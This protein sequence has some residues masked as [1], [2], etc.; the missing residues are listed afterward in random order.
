MWF[1]FPEGVTEISVEQQNFHP[2]V[3]RERSVGER[4]VQFGFFR[5]PDHFAPT[6][7][8]LGM[9]FLSETPEGDLSELPPMQSGPPP[10]SSTG[11][12]SVEVEALRNEASELRARL[13]SVMA[14]RDDLRVRAH[15]LEVALSDVGAEAP[16]EAAKP[17]AGASGAGSPGKGSRV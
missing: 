12:S 16:A 10:A 6:I 15:E 14:E 3:E 8:G 11:I 13:A 17:G 9:G 2:E 1:R 7:L 5:A 4:K